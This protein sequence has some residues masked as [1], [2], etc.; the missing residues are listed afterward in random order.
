MNSIMSTIARQSNASIAIGD[1]QQARYNYLSAIDGF[2]RWPDE[3]EVIQ[4]H[5]RAGR[6]YA[7][8]K[9]RVREAIKGLP[10]FGVEAM[11]VEECHIR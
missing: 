4:E 3:A 9:A 10:L 7:A 11:L 8:A 2:R 6:A 5:E 1:L